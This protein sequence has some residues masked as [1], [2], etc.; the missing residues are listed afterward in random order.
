M[1]W[2]QLCLLIGNMFVKG[3]FPPASNYHQTT[4]SNDYFQFTM[5]YF[6]LQFSTQPSLQIIEYL[7]HLRTVNSLKEPTAVSPSKSSSLAVTS[8]SKTSSLFHRY[9]IPHHWLFHHYSRHPKPHHY[10]ITIQ[11]L[12]TG[13]FITA[14]FKA[15]SLTINFITIQDLITDYFSS[16]LET[17]SSTIIQNLIGEYSITTQDLVTDHFITVNDIISI[18]DFATKQSGCHSFHSS[19]I[20]N[21]NQPNNQSAKYSSKHKNRHPP[22]PKKNPTQTNKKNKKKTRRKKTHSTKTKC[23]QKTDC[24]PVIRWRLQQCT[25]QACCQTKD[26]A[27]YVTSL[28]SDEDFSDVRDGSAVRWRL[29][30]NVRDEPVVRRRL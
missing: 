9:P 30:S 6:S 25:W 12:T 29:Q 11:Y 10:S 3:Y 24:E 4:H 17:S 22:P 1:L 16:V 8:L 7:H 14:L 18:D 5:N 15:S 28:W 26:L 13:Y 27:M 19:D 20:I 2:R 21:N 23:T